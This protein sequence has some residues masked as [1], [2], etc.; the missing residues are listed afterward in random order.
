[1]SHAPTLKWSEFK[2]GQAYVPG[3]DSGLDFEKGYLAKRLVFVS[4][5]VEGDLVITSRRLDGPGQLYF[6][7]NNDR[8]TALDDDT[9]R[10]DSP[11]ATE[12]TYV[13]AHIPTHFP[14]PPGIAHH[15]GGYLIPRPGC[16]QVEATIQDYHVQIVF[17]VL[18]E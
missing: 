6:V 13:D 4:D 14:N 1:M 18:D 9:Y 15:G 11:L 17:E 2:G 16:Y 8:F 7:D 12:Q 5:E 3:P 10:I